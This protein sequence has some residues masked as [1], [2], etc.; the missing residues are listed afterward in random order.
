MRKTKTVLYSIWLA[1]VVCCLTVLPSLAQS[2][3][4][5]ATLTVGDGSG[6][7]GSQGN[8]ITVT[9]TNDVPVGGM[10]VEICD[11][12]NFMVCAGCQ[13]VDRASNFLCSL[14]ELSDGCCR[15]ILVDVTGGGLAAGSG[16]ILSVDYTVATK[17]PAGHAGN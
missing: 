16:P 5:T 17:A 11:E 6:T 13:G 8:H 3:G 15:M 4:G 10:Q 7:P 2:Q 9:L 1:S 12:E 14:N